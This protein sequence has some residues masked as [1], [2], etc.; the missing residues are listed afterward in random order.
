MVNVLMNTE[1][2]VGDWRVV[3]ATGQIIRDNTDI[4]LE[5]KAMAVLIYLAEHAG[6]AVTR[7]EL[8]ESV[9][10]GTVVTYDALSVTINKI[11]AAL[12]DNSRNPHFIETLAKRG[13]RLIAPVAFSDINTAAAVPSSTKWSSRILLPAAIAL[14]AAISLSALLLYEYISNESNTA[15]ELTIPQNIPSIAVIPFTNISGDES[16][17]YFAAGMTEYLITDLSRLSSLIVISRTSV[18]GYNSHNVNINEVSQTLKARYILTGSIARNK[19]SMRVAVQLTDS[20]NGIQLWADRFDRKLDDLFTVQDEI[21]G[22]IVRKLVTRVGKSEQNIKSHNYTSNHEAHDYFIRGN[23]LYT[24]I[25]KEGNALAR[26][27]FFKAIDADPGFASAYSAIA[28]TYIDDYRRKWGDDPKG[29]VDRAFEYANK[30]ITVDNTAAAAYVVQ[31]YAYLYGRKD[32]EKSITAAKHAIKLYPNYADAYAI[33]GSAYSFVS[34]SEDAIR[35]NNHALKLNPGSSYIY[36][37][38]LGRDYYFLGQTKKAIARLK[39]AIYRNEA[40]LNAHL[41]LAAVYASLGKT[42]DASWEVEQVLALDPGFSLNY[43][44]GTQPYRSSD[45][46]EQLL[47]DLRKAGLPG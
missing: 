15:R 5:P 19:N 2:M 10:Q 30:A 20:S 14:V 21:A 27:M 6:Q 13:Y 7:N 41:Y 42:E 37:V 45:R 17:D 32:P 40:Y 9:W 22:N 26:E 4:R 31:S 3:P 35:V 34:R 29:A 28:L 18:L 23:A 33:I 8:E 25:S 1:F 24:S 46:L 11:R 36:H 47:T 44:A 12:G 16:Q 39:D 43:W 38:N